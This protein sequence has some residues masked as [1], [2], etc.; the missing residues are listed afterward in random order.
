[1]SFKIRDH[2]L[3]NSRGTSIITCFGKAEAVVIPADIAELDGFYANTLVSSV[4]FEAGSRLSRIESWA[5]HSC[6]S[7]SS[8][9]IPSSVETLG[10]DCFSWCTKLSA[11]TFETGSKLSHIESG[12]FQS[13][14]SL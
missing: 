4:T 14:S 12:T 5:F 10:R 3:V 6:F 9:C 2:F 8:I 1:V 11:A 7:L 13:C